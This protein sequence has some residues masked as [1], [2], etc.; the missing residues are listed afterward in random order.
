MIRNAAGTAAA[1]EDV[2]LALSSTDPP[3]TILY[4]TGNSAFSVATFA[5]RVSTPVAG[6]TPAIRSLWTVSVGFLS[7]RQISGQSWEYSTVAN[8]SSGTV[9]QFGMGIWRVRSA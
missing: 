8:L 1:T 5:R 2:D 6:S 9:P 7:R 3:G 4:P